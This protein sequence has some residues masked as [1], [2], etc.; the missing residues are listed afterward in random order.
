MN[1][2]TMNSAKAFLYSH[3]SL[4]LLLAL[5]FASAFIPAV[6]AQD[7]AS[8]D[9]KAALKAVAQMMEGQRTYFQKN[10]AFRA[11]VANIQQDFGIN[12][13]AS[14]D[15]AVRTTTEAAYSYVIPAQSSQVGQL[16]AYVGAAFLTPSQN[17]KITT[18][19][20]KN[21]QP[22][23]IRPS[24]PQLVLGT[25]VANPTGR[26]VQCGDASIEVKASLVNE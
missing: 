8:P 19:I 26:I 14:F 22:G 20:C 3:F 21:I 11:T 6:R 13:P 23:Q 9:Q 12:L 18:I 5:G 7:Q 2:D 15:Y 1:N 16:N 24:D 10:G 25:L 17:P 4:I